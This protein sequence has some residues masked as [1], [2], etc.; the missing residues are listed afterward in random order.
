M[1]F[2]DSHEWMTEKGR[3]GKALC[4]PSLSNIEAGRLGVHGHHYLIKFLAT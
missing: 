3:V 1:K 4:N 2:K